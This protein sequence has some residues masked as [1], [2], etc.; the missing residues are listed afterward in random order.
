MCLDIFSN[1]ESLVTLNKKEMMTLTPVVSDEHREQ[2]KQLILQAAKEAFISKGFNATTIQDIINHSGVSRGGVY[3][4]YQNTEDIF[5][6]LLR[7]RDLEDV[8]DVDQLY[9]DGMTSL[10]AITYVLAQIEEGIQL[11]KDPLVPAIYEYYFTKGRG[12]K[13]HLL[14]LESRI[15][16]AEKSL[17]QILQ[18]GIDEQEFQPALPIEDIARTILTFSDGMYVNS[19][20]LGPEKVKLKSQF[21]TFRHYLFTVLG[22]S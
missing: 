13:K 18:K 3:T 17:V 22:V 10:Q 9:R 21:A 8:L 4:Y 2:R 6:D 12:T 7:K 15:E 11:Q 5:I 20:H 19:F 14:L 1:K 16:Q